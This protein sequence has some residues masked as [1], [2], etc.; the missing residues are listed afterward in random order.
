MEKMQ[1]LKAWLRS[2]AVSLGILNEREKDILD[3]IVDMYGFGDHDP[4]F[5]TPQTSQ[6]TAYLVA[7]IKRLGQVLDVT[8]DAARTTQIVSLIALIISLTAL[9][10][11]CGTP[12]SVSKLERENIKLQEQQIELLKKLNKELAIA[13]NN[14]ATSPSAKNK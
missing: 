14:K 13:A 9:F 12:D 10:T 3:E 7:V 4:G 8:H 2:R 6:E 11:S 1:K 5:M